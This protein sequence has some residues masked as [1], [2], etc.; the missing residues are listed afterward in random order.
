MKT[1]AIMV[2]KVRLSEEI[3][4][5][6][7]SFSSA[8]V[9]MARWTYASLGPLDFPPDFVHPH[10]SKYKLEVKAVMV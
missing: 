2:E 3:F 4:R 6:E 9:V 1:I 10:V 7:V 8:I 5:F